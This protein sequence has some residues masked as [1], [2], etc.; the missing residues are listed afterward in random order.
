MRGALFDALII[1]HPQI[2]LLRTRA[3]VEQVVPLSKEEFHIGVRSFAYLS[4]PE[5]HRMIEV[6]G[7]ARLF[8]Q[9]K[10][11]IESGNFGARA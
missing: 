8:F 11:E 2:G 3:S 9:I 4:L 7:A 6:A 10:S 1:D 5:D